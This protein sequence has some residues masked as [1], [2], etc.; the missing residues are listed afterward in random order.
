M[1][2]RFQIY[3]LAGQIIKKPIQLSSTWHGGR[4]LLTILNPRCKTCLGA[5][6]QLEHI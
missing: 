4:K 1:S 2:Y 3:A 5:L 6:G